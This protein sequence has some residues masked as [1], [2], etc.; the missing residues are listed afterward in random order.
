MAAAPVVAV[1]DAG[2]L[3]YLDALG[4]LEAVRGLYRL[5][6]P[7]AVAEELERRPGAFGGGAPSMAGVELRTPESE[8]MRLVSSGPPAIDA[9]E[10][11]VIAL[12]LGMGPLAVMDER[13]G[14]RRASRLGVEVVGTL[15][16][17]IEIH[18]AG[19]ARRTFAEDL[20]ALG[21]AGMYLTDALKERVMERYREVGGG[22]A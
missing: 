15:A 22:G 9:G 14:V 7:N 20:D 13:R 17:L 4:Y 11:E 8:D 3:I 18:R 12:A 1:F 21:N 10:K 19:Y 2:P 6:V 16:F 5:V